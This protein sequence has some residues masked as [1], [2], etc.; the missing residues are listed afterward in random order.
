M[1][2]EEELE[3]SLYIVG[4]PPEVTEDIIKDIFKDVIDTHIEKFNFD[5]DPKKTIINYTILAK[6]RDCA[7]QLYDKYNDRHYSETDPKLKDKRITLTHYLEYH[8]HADHIYSEEH[9]KK[10]QDLFNSHFKWPEN[11]AREY[12]TDHQKEYFDEMEIKIKQSFE[13]AKT[14]LGRVKNN[15]LETE[16]QAKEIEE[17][18]SRFDIKFA[19]EWK[20]AEEQNEK[21]ENNTD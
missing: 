8:R 11:L 10:L 14:E 19:E 5:K 13:L 2:K 15:Y 9:L 6:S 4:V 1:S 18:V 3:R 20:R 16:K 7:T 12:Y 21:E 17:M